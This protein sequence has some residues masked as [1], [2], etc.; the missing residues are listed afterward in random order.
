MRAILTFNLPRDKYDYENCMNGAKYLSVLNEFANML[1]SKTKYGD[2]G[3]AQAG[4]EEAREEFWR[5]C[6][7]EGVDPYGG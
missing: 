2:G 3:K 6:Q 5:I 1:R 7:E 4:W